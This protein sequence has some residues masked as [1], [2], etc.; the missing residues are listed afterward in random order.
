MNRPIPPAP[1]TTRHRH[2]PR[3]FTL[4]EL[5]VVIAVLGI[6]LAISLPALA[7]ARQRA[8]TVACLSQVR[9]LAASFAA[10]STSNRGRLPENRTLVTTGE[11]ITWRELFIREGYMPRSKAWACPAHPGGE[12]ASELGMI[13]NGTA[14]VGDVPSSYAL[15]GHLLWRSTKLP[16]SADRP[17]TV[18]FRPDRTILTAETRAHFPDLRVTS[19]I[20]AQDSES[21]E[22]GLFGYW[23]AGDGVYGFLDGHAEQI[24]MFDTGNP[25][26][27]WHNGKDFT[28]DPLD[29]MP[30]RE[31]SPHAHPDWQYLLHPVYL[32]RRAPR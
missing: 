24:N 6:V 9:Q 2:H 21:R 1:P 5:L 14:C 23:H 13:D 20:V 30:E 26:C 31:A 10:F 4:I 15:N 22:G 7:G 17:E 16:R 27:R 8:R 11:H 25:D 12:P 18:V 29:P 19:Y 28:D 32:Q 3:A